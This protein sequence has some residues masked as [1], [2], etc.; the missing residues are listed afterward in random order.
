MKGLYA[1][2]LYLF[3]KTYRGEYGEELQ[4]VFDLSLDDAAGF[5]WLEVAIVICRELA[6]MPKAILYAHM[7]EM[8]KA[9]MKKGFES[10]FDFA[11]GSWHEFLTALFPFLLGGSIP[12]INYL[13]GKGLFSNDAGSVVALVMLVLF[14]VLLVVGINRGMP[15][16]SLPYL[17]FLFSILS[18]FMLSAVFGTPIYLLFRDLRDQSVL[19]IDILWDGIFWYGLLCAILLLVVL[20]RF[21][22]AFQRFRD[23]WTLPCFVLYGGAPFALWLTF[24]EYV[25]D[26][27]YVLLALL[28]LAAGAWIYL[29]SA[30]MGTRFATLFIA[31]TAAMFIAAIGKWLLVPSQTW[32]IQIDEGLAKAEFRHTVAMWGWFALGMII[33]PASRFFMRPG[34]SLR[35]A[36]S[37]K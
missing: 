4:A 25:G 27:P 16:W 19:L 24:D 36:L 31:M 15:R 18:V 23:D 26:E 8:R 34:D 11:H 29:R 37:E 30:G 22:P 20:G 17:G 13:G 14:L 10:Y 1:L 35:S 28:V 33:P 5:G 12:L 9:K 7:R 32:P 6:G 21:S 2:L 3:P